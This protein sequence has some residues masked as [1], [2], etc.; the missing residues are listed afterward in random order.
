MVD[1]GCSFSNGVGRACFSGFDD[2]HI[3]AVAGEL[4]RDNPAV[5]AI[6]T[7]SREYDRALPQTLWVAPRDL[8]CR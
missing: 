3:N 1:S 2:G 6:V 4:R 7:R 8:A 5:S